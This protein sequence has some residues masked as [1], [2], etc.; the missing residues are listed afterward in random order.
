MLDLLGD[1]RR[2]IALIELKGTPH[3]VDQWMERHRPAEG[4]RLPFHPCR[5]ARDLTP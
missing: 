2:G 4:D 3:E 1:D 5:L